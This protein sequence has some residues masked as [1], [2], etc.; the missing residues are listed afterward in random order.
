MD[1]K[2]DNGQSQTHEAFLKMRTEKRLK[3]RARRISVV[4]GSACSIMDGCGQRYMIP[5]ALALGA[6]NREIGFLS[7]FPSILGAV[8]QLITIRM[9]G[10]FSRRKLLFFSV[11]SQ[12]LMWLM[13]IFAGYRYYYC[14]HGSMEIINLLT[15]IYTLLALFG[16]MLTPAWNSWMNDIVPKNRGRYFGKRN[17]IVG[18]VAMVSMLF[19]GLFMDVFKKNHLFWGFAGLFAVSFLARTV[20][21]LLFLIQ[22]E[23]PFRQEKGSFFSFRDFLLRIYE[24]NFGRFVVFVSLIGFSTMI[25]APFF[26]VYMLNELQMSYTGY[27]AVVLASSLTNMIFMPAWGKFA[28]RYG[29]FM[30]M[31][32]CGILVAIVPLLW[33]VSPQVHSILPSLVV[34]VLVLIEG[35]SGIAWAG[36]SLANGNYIFEAVTRQKLAICV[37]YFNIIYSIGVFAGGMLGG[38]LGNMGIRLSGSG[39]LFVFLISGFARL[40]TYL[41]M[42]G[43]IREVR[44]V[45]KFR[46]RDAIEMIS[47]LNLMKIVGIFR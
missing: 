46:L 47:H 1:E 5:Y 22:Y 14:P 10:K 43:R 13:M 42:I 17:Q 35:F 45:K 2:I 33:L 24:N 32:I 9:L 44:I 37:A 34:P 28:D 25:S 12:A 6:Q 26:S 8:S 41:L 18:L 27:T 29:N 11:F 31:R 3:A 7:S 38:Y 39:L 30:V 15:V 36:F 40:A 16:S 20:S 4:E 23:P 19:A 21:A